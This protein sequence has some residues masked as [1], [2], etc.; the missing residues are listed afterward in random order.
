MASRGLSTPAVLPGR[1]VC[2]AQL[3]GQRCETGVRGPQRALLH[4]RRGEQM[5]VDPSDPPSAEPAGLHELHDLRMGQGASPMDL[6]IRREQLRTRPSALTNQ[7][8]PLDEIVTEYLVIGQELV[9]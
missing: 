3:S 1:R 5:G 7:E 8:F 2:D 6:G 4:Q 9:Q